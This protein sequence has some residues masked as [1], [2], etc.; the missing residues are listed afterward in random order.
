MPSGTLRAW[1]GAACVSYVSQALLKLIPGEKAAAQ[2]HFVT[3]S[4][5][6]WASNL[7]CVWLQDCSSLGSTWL[8]LTSSSEWP[9]M[10]EQ[11][12]TSGK[13]GE[14][15]PRTLPSQGWGQRMGPAHQL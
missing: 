1:S 2:G 8:L 10:K 7:G 5:S 6:V 15:M 9:A 12:G 3:C 14:T 13:T 11:E 4:E